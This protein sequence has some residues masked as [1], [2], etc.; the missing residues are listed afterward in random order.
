MASQE[1]YGGGLLL[2]HMSAQALR[3]T[4]RGLDLIDKAKAKG[5]SVVGEIYPHDF[6]GTILMAAYLHPDNYGSN[7]G[8]SCSD[9]IETATVTPLTKERYDELM[10][11]APT[12]N[13]MFYNAQT[14]DVCKG[15]AHPTSVQG[16]D[17]MP[18]VM[19]SDGSPALAWDV[20]FEA[21]NA[22]PVAP[23]RTRNS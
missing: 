2:M 9:I 4:Q 1:I 22:P 21:V 7:M 11:T 12:A 13:V 5:L 16:S 19:K 20:P 10:K 17:A 23:A 3:D 14:E 18:Y 15:L 6:G 8:R